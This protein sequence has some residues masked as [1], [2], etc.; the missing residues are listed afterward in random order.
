MMAQDQHRYRVQFLEEL[1]S[2]FGDLGASGRSSDYLSRSLALPVDSIDQIAAV[3]MADGLIRKVESAQGAGYVLTSEGA[4][5]FATRALG[6]GSEALEKTLS[7]TAIEALVAYA[8]KLRGPGL[9]AM[10][11]TALRTNRYPTF[12]RTTENNL[13]RL[14]SDFNQPYRSAYL[15]RFVNEALHPSRPA[16]ESADLRAVLRSES[17]LGSAKELEENRSSYEGERQK[18]GL[19]ELER[20][21]RSISE[22]TD[23]AQRGYAFEDLLVSLFQTFGLNPRQPYR[24]TGG[25]FDGAFLLDGRHY[26]LE[27]K[28]TSERVSNKELSFF[29]TKVMQ[30]SLGPHGL[31]VSTA[32]FSTEAVRFWQGRG[33]CPVVLAEGAD[34]MLVLEGR[35]GLPELLREKIRA[36]SQEGRILRSA[37]EI[38]AGRS[39]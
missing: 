1:Y 37:Q 24:V 21:F 34:V 13:R 2:V 31:F 11:T 23:P 8:W 20:R 33:A 14:F 12:S 5:Y 39:A 29:I 36:A 6:V 35:I 38:L 4:R 18:N 22:I 3:M 10:L 17:L 16:S 32:G 27:A 7:A 15:T 28:W 26:L 25:Q 9:K 19:V 30:Q